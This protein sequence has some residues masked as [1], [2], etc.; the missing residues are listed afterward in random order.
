MLDNKSALLHD[1]L[2]SNQQTNKTETGATN[3]MTQAFYRAKFSANG[4]AFGFTSE[5]REWLNSTTINGPCW[6]YD[7]WTYGLIEATSSEWK[8]VTA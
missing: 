5:M 2:V 7:A 4:L 3:V 8:T 6:V 1:W